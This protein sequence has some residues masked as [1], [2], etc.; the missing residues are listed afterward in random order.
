LRQGRHEVFRIGTFWLPDR[1][2]AG[3]Q[4]ES[5]APRVRPV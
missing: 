5:R 2:V 3:V 1:A 4:T